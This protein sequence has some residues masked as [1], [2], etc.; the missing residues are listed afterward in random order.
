MLNTVHCNFNTSM[1]W[2]RH[3][4]QSQAIYSQIILTQLHVIYSNE[5]TKVPNLYGYWRANLIEFSGNY[6][7]INT[8]NPV[9]YCRNR[10]VSKDSNTLTLITLLFQ[11]FSV[12]IIF[13]ISSLCFLL[14]SDFIQP[15]TRFNIML[16]Y[17]YL[18]FAFIHICYNYIL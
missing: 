9:L 13:Q 3:V 7:Q 10:F 2:T 12:I 5:S 18:G 4:Q 11:Q 6:F 15:S 1:F 14:S 17:F 8:L 16:F